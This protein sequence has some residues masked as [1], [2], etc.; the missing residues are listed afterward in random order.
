MSKSYTCLNANCKRKSRAKEV[1]KLKYFKVL[2][3]EQSKLQLNIHKSLK[4][5]NK[6]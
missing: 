1:K 4:Q 5:K 2:L 6:K 3:R